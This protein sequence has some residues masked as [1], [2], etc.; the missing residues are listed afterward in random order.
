MLIRA[1][2]YA[3]GERVDVGY[4]RGTV[5]GIGPAGIN[6][7]DREANWIAPSLFDLQINGCRGIAFSSQALT[8]EQVRN[9]VDE[10][11]RH[12]VA[13]L[14]PT[15]VTNSYAA[16]AHGIS[17]LRRAVET[18]SVVAAAVPGFHLEGT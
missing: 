5:T 7:A 6:R 11:H 15:L 2:H 9:V 14:L 3:T 10:C 4:D 8:Q 16:L 1:R 13:G 17:T 18:D 12:G